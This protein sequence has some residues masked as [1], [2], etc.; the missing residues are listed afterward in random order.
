VSR[1]LVP[2]FAKQSNKQKATQL[3]KKRHL[4]AVQKK[5]KKAALFFACA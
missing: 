4:K 2:P 3:Q 1:L 5:G